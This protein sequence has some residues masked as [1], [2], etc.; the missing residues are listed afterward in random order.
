[1]EP[2]FY[3]GYD[4]LDEAW[5]TTNLD[6]ETLNVTSESQAYAQQYDA[7]YA[8]LMQNTDLNSVYPPCKQ[9]IIRIAANKGQSYIG[10]HAEILNN[11]NKTYINDTQS[12]AALCIDETGTIIIY[13]YTIFLINEHI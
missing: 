5:Q 10:S 4:P 9:N 3:A 11:S 13:P 7:S 2:Q 12:N 6:A 1:M 8:Y